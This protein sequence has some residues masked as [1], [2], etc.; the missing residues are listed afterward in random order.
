M[1][2]TQILITD[3]PKKRF[4]EKWPSQLES[5]LF[6]EKFSELKARLQYYTP[7]PFLHRI[8][9][10]LDDEESALK[11]YEFLKSIVENQDSMKLF[12]TESLLGQPR[13][14]S[15]D[16]SFKIGNIFDT[17]KEKPILLL[18]TNPSNTGIEVS[19]LAAGSPS[20]SP[21]KTSLE[22][23]TLL[24]FSEGNELHYYKE[25]LPKQNS[26]SELITPVTSNASR[27]NEKTYLFRPALNLDTAS[28]SQN[29]NNDSKD[30]LAS[31][32]PKSPSITINE[33]HA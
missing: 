23:P 3:I 24:K 32:P 14:R 29:N 17:N 28:I 22:S 16:D 11:V 12:L 20:L 7:L 8:V 15:F 31:S 30:T 33:F 1:G 6:E 2:K 5:L 19:S 25:P 26:S 21:D 9:I 18:D 10:I 4:D 13:S 27:D